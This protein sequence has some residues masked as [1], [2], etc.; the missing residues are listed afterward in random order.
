MAAGTYHGPLK[1]T[2]EPDRLPKDSLDHGGLRNANLGAV[3]DGGLGVQAF[4]PLD[5]CAGF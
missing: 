5:G 3:T 1:P 4:S 2:K